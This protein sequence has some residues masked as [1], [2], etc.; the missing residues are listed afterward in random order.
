MFYTEV[1]PEE[2]EPEEANEEDS[3]NSQQTLR[4]VLPI[5][6]LIMDKEFI[7][8]HF[9]VFPNTSCISEKSGFMEDLQAVEQGQK[10]F[11]SNTGPL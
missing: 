8:F 7:H 2:S 3:D 5:S 9:R 4:E 1:H 11:C 6:N 10:N